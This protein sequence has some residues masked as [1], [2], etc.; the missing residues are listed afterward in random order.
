MPLNMTVKA[1]PYD[2]HLCR[3]DL[4]PIR[5]APELMSMNLFVLEYRCKRINIYSIIICNSL[6]L[7]GGIPNGI[8]QNKISLIPLYKMIV[9]P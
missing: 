4:C 6:Q 5:Q 9:F 1:F 2:N 3:S 8:L 7:K